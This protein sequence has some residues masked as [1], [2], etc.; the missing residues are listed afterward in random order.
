MSR[1]STSLHVRGRLRAAPAASAGSLPRARFASCD[2][3]N[4]ARDVKMLPP[5]G[6]SVSMQ[7]LLPVA[8][9]VQYMH[10]ADRSSCNRDLPSVPAPP[11]RAESCNPPVP[12]RGGGSGRLRLTPYRPLPRPAASRSSAR[13]RAAPAPRGRPAGAG[14]GPRAADGASRPPVRPRARAPPS[15]GLKGPRRPARRMAA[16]KPSGRKIRLHKKTR[17]TEPVPTWILLRTKRKV[18]TNPKRRAWR[19]TDVEVG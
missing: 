16:R 12:W 10:L 13:M 6:E 1:V 11:R 2:A 15:I 14:S 7:P 8:V 3:P 5:C 17:Q 18:R 9:F 19:Q 4:F